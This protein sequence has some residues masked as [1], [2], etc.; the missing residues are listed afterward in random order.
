MRNE[1]LS[2]EAQNPPLSKTDVTC[3]FIGGFQDTRTNGEDFAIT[4]YLF[5][6]WVTG[7]ILKVRGIGLCW[8]YYSVYLGLGWNIPSNYP[9]F[10]NLSKN[11]L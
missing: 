6:V 8:G 5:A 9:S 4:P 11:D 1:K 7:K 10:K 3:R 2:N